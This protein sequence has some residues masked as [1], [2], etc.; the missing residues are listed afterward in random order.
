MASREK[1]SSEAFLLGVEGGAESPVIPAALSQGT[2]VEVRD[3]FFNTPAR[4]KFLKAASTESGRVQQDLLKLALVHPEVAFTLRL[5]GKLDT[6]AGSVDKVALW[7]AREEGR[8]Q[9]ER[10]GHF[11]QREGRDDAT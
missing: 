7:M 6:I 9:G 2:R 3:L 5:D 1:G 10:T 11:R 4:L 8:Q